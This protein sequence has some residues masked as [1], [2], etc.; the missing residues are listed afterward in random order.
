MGGTFLPMKNF[1]PSIP[2]DL[3]GDQCRGRIVSEE[4]LSMT[5]DEIQ[6]Q[7]GIHSLRKTAKLKLEYIKPKV[8][9]IGEG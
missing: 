4:D 7:V 2:L 3:E 6:S 9:V 8:E 1:D 5:E